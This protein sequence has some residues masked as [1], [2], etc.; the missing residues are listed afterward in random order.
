MRKLPEGRYC[1][2]SIYLGVEYLYAAKTACFTVAA[3]KLTYPGHLVFT[4]ATRATKELF[5][6]SSNPTVATTQL[7]RDYPKALAGYGV[8]ETPFRRE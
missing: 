3:N 6:L 5:S 7:R 4:R 2:S 1:V 8:V